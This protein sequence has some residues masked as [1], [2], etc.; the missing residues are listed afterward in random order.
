MTIRLRKDFS[1]MK[2][3]KHTIFILTIFVLL[4]PLSSA[5]AHRPL[6]GEQYGPI[7]IPNLHTSFA[8]YRDLAVDQID[9]YT[10]EANA[11]QELHA[12]IQIP[13]VDGL[14][15]YGVSAALF[16]PGL[17][18]ANLASLP[19]D[20]PE[21][22]GA[23]VFPS[24]VS[25]DFFEPFT[26]TRYWG[27]QE[28]DLSLPADGMYYLLIWQPEG[29]PGKYVLDTGRAEVFEPA[30]LFRF[31]IWWLRVHIFFGHGSALSLLGALIL[32]AGTL[33]VIRKSRKG[34]NHNE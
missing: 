18:E 24:S 27:R 3:I 26:Q 19:P 16:G 8:I 17:P 4:I 20:H 31:P 12:G 32:F 14:K 5:A 34:A 13:A 10:F 22:L 1:R 33:L 30:D 21:N 23:L 28:I 2:T 11:K 7:E 25:A 29:R 15:D 9:V 6:W